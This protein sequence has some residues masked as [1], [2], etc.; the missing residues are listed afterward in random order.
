MFQTRGHEYIHCEN[1]FMFTVQ[2]VTQQCINPHVLTQYVA[3]G[4]K[5]T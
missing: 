4:L 1:I 5:D 2:Q 3:A